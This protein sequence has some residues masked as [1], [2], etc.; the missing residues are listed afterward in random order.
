MIFIP[1]CSYFSF[2]GTGINQHWARGP[3]AF[4][5]VM[6]VYCQELIVVSL[7]PAFSDCGRVC[8]VCRVNG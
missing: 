7:L 1:H 6:L 3:L 2:F 4:L 8:G 5:A